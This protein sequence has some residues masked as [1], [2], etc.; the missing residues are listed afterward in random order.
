MHPEWL[1]RRCAAACNAS[2]L[3]PNAPGWHGVASIAK[4][5]GGFVLSDAPPAL[6]LAQ[7]NAVRRLRAWLETSGRDTG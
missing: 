4:R 2:V 7:R 5:Q 6:D 1:W 3:W